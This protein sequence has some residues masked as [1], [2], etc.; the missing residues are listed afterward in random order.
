MPVAALNAS[1][2]IRYDYH[3]PQQ[4]MLGLPVSN[5]QY[6]QAAFFAEE[7]VVLI[8]G[9]KNSMLGNDVI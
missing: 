3:E 4:V 7:G 5:D 9:D 8:E 6:Q 1:E 2:S